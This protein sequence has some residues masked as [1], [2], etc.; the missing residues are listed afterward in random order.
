MADKDIKVLREQSNGSFK[1]VVLGD[2]V[3]G[4]I[5]DKDVRIQGTKL[6]YRLYLQN[7]AN[8]DPGEPLVVDGRARI[9]H[10]MNFLAGVANFTGASDHCH[11]G[12]NASQRATW[13]MIQN[14]PPSDS[15]S[16]YFT[17][18]TR[19][20]DPIG[21]VLSPTILH[22]IDTRD[23]VNSPV[24]PTYLADIKINW[25][26][27]PTSLAAG[28][29]V[30]VQFTTGAVGIAAG[31]FPGTIISGPT[32]LS[33]DVNG[34]P[35]VL[36]QYVI[37]LQGMDPEHWYPQFKGLYVIN[38]G[39]LTNQVFRV[40]YG[41]QEIQGTRNTLAAFPGISRFANVTITNHNA[42]DGESIVLKIGG[43]TSI[44]GL[45]P[46][47][48]NGYVRHVI[49]ANQFVI[50]IGNAI[51][52]WPTLSG[53]VGSSADWRIIKGTTDNNHQYTPALQQ[54]TFERLPTADTSTLTTG[55]NKNVALG[56]SA[57]AGGNFS[58]ALGY[59]A[60]V[61]SD[62]SAVVGGENNL[63]LPGANNSTII[64]GSN[65]IIPA[66]VNNAVIINGSNVTA[67]ESNTVYVP[68]L[69]VTQQ[70]QAPNQ[71]TLG[72]GLP[73]PAVNLWRPT[74]VNDTFGGGFVAPRQFNATTKGAGDI[75]PFANYPV[76]HTEDLTP[77]QIQNGVYVECVILGK[78]SKKKSKRLTVTPSPW[79]G[80]L[81]NGTWQKAPWTYPW[82][83]NFQTRTGEHNY[84][85]TTGPIGNQTHVNHLIAMNRPNHFLVT[86][87]IAGVADQ[88]AFVP[89][90]EFLN[91]RFTTA[92][93]DY[94][95]TNGQEVFINAL[96]P[97][98]N[99]RGYISKRFG[100]SSNCRPLRIA[101]RYIMWDSTAQRIVSGPLSKTVK[102]WYSIFPFFV[103]HVASTIQQRTTVTIN[104]NFNASTQLK[105]WLE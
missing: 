51:N 42:Y 76:V 41:F 98:D 54:V 65:N 61:F 33:V 43:S 1:E 88:R 92:P 25:T 19:G 71:N 30:I 35:V 97:L 9:V 44:L 66:T 83:S 11:V 89:V 64:G 100:Y 15:S 53:S 37:R 49:D 86:P 58:Y 28:S 6:G 8:F 55:G 80:Q 2:P 75:I 21:T 67:T 84:T 95:N 3:E 47:D 91:G 69:V 26:A 45:N 40:I 57:E 63:I 10:G 20:K 12:W 62:K 72:G 102:I 52:G 70:L 27:A 39:E 99:N 59:K 81:V 96:I 38:S 74:L 79:R 56:N 77:A 36:H 24:A 32:Q 4:T 82:P 46:G 48:Y 105:C 14:G 104:P 93:V 16:N 60:G 29:S 87:P 78:K 7:V 94:I 85:V 68:R 17:L 23:T 13:Q 90:Y 34:T 73:V 103:D 31:M 22:S 101:F 5:V 18:H 50:S